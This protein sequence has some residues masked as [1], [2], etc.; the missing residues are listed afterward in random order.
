LK[1]THNSNAINEFKK[2]KDT[3]ANKKNVANREILNSLQST[4][5]DFENLIKIDDNKVKIKWQK[6]K[7]NVEILNDKYKDTK[8]ENN[9]NDNKNKNKVKY[10]IVKILN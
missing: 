2:F 9:N 3:F 8:Y 7:N 10:K 4:N 5:N 1:A 6:T